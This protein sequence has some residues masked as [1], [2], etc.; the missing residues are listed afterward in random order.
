MYKIVPLVGRRF[1][2]QVGEVCERGG[3]RSRELH[4]VGGQLPGGGVGPYRGGGGA[5]LRSGDEKGGNTGKAR[6]KPVGREGVGTSAGHA[7]KMPR[8]KNFRRK[9]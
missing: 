8:G 3:R 6:R 9:V 5:V 4:C 7:Q 2:W 1:E